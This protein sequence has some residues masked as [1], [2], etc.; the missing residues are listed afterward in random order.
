MAVFQA[1]LEYILSFCKTPVRDESIQ[2]RSSSCCWCQF[3]WSE[4]SQGYRRWDL[5][6]SSQLIWHFRWLN[7]TYLDSRSRWDRRAP[8]EW[9]DRILGHLSVQTSEQHPCSATGKSWSMAR[10]MFIETIYCRKKMKWNNWKSKKSKPK[11][12][13]NI[14]LNWRK[15]FELYANAK[16]RNGSNVRLT[17]HVDAKRKKRPDG[18]FHPAEIPYSTIRRFLFPD[19]KRWLRLFHPRCPQS[20]KKTTKPSSWNSVK[21]NFTD[22]QQRQVRIETSSS[23]HSLSLLRL[24]ANLSKL[25][26]ENYHSI[27]SRNAQGKTPRDVAHDAGHQE[28]VEQIGE[29]P[30]PHPRSNAL[31]YSRWILPR[32]ITEWKHQSHSRFVAVRLHRLSQSIEDQWR[33]QWRNRQLHQ[34]RSAP[35]LSK[36]DRSLEL[37]VIEVHRF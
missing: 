1:S 12:K 6:I 23:F 26:R 9:P 5:C 4:V 29:H 21:Q 19:T 27:A 34:T 15:K 17:K 14:E 30:R 35:T 11:K 13:N 10:P 8:S 32:A 37:V 18:N 20:A 28:N 3:D 2:F 7:R 36:I 25:L 16:N 33:D 24:D 22:K 31:L